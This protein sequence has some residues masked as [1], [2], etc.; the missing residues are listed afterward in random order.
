VGRDLGPVFDSFLD[1]GGA[2]RVTLDLECRPGAAPVL[3]LAQRRQLPLGSRGAAAATAQVWKV[4]LCVRYAE[5]RGGRRACTLLEAP[6]AALSLE[7][8]ACPAW[9]LPNDSMRGY[10]RASLRGELSLPR[11]L[12]VAWPN[13]TSAERVG[14]F[15]DLRAQVSSGEVE[16]GAA[17][18]TLPIALRDGNRYALEAAMDLAT[19]LR[20]DVLSPALRPKYEQFLRSVFGAR[21]LALGFEVPAK[22]DDS[23]RLLRPQL[24]WLVGRLGREPTLRAKSLALA[25]SWLDDRGAIHPDLVA[26]VLRIAADTDD[27][28]LHASLLSAVLS[29]PDREDR[30]HLLTAL[31]NFRAPALVERHLLLTLDERLDPREGLSLLWA[32]GWDFR[33]RE[34]GLGF[35]RRH[36]EALI[37]RLPTD[38]GAD[39]VR[40]AAGACDETE[41]DA[42]KTFF[43]GRSTKFLG[44]QRQLDE[45]ME[46]ID[47]CI[48]WRAR[49]R[50]S[51]AQFIE[52]WT[53]PSARP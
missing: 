23:T 4:P 52:R 39:L 5:A 25:K 29:E 38:T 30:A 24:L 37:A 51:A 34:L 33:S 28:T 22:E 10:F 49:H 53:P 21:A 20:G 14:L 40:V 48:A 32:A 42:V 9:V 16:L 19:N 47:L 1:Q 46:A 50:P 35:L 44:G 41:R 3:H 13:L 36:W 11:L 2:P 27:T 12:E 18:A 43:D 6:E 45:T 31:G 26:T 7:G 17:L 15:G 8:Q